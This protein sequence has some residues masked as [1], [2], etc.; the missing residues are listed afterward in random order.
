MK[1]KIRPINAFPIEAEG[2]KLICLQDPMKISD[3][4]IF[5]DYQTYF[6]ISM[7]DGNNEVS[8]I[9]LAYTRQFGE[10]LLNNQIDALLKD[11]DDSLF[12]EG[13]KYNAM[14][15]QLRQ[16]FAAEPVRRAEHDGSAYESEPVKLRKQLDKVLKIAGNSAK[17]NQQPKALIAP[18]IDIRVG[19]QGYAYSYSR[20]HKEN[21][22]DLYIIL[23]VSH[24]ASRNEFIITAKDFETPF[25][26]SKTNKDFVG[27]LEDALPV[28]SSEDKFIHKSEHSI[29][30][31]LV[32]LQHA[33]GDANYR[34]VP[35]LCGGFHTQLEKGKMPEDDK[36]VK[37]FLEALRTAIDDY[38][39]T[40]CIIAGVDLS[41]IGTKFGSV[42]PITQAR[43]PAIEQLDKEML[44]YVVRC[45]VRGFYKNI[46]MD[47]NGRN[48]CGFGAIYTL[49]FLLGDSKCELLHYGQNYQPETS[50]VVTFASLAFY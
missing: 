38:K 30:F 13:E 47:K 36:A 12:L 43:L 9:Q 11:L 4:T 5:I 24:M 21:A 37:K 19:A 32:F 41:H 50:S 28:G 8:D 48:V 3:K 31:Q 2:R 34:I 46:E 16:S 25:G 17:N 39:G 35:I 40:V 29:E 42:S 23:G 14:M 44:D 27:I 18:H 7:M 15:K 20:I 33:L 10:L 26:I 22:A 49:L 6:I 45:D 1:P